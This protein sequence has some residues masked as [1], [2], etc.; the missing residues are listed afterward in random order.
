M[1]I[2]YFHQHF[3]TPNG[4]GGT[5]SYEFAKHLVNQGHQVTIITGKFKDGDTGLKNSFIN[6]KREGVVEGINILELNI[7]YSNKNNFINRSLKFLLFS[8]RGIFISLTKEY[9]II[10]S[11]STP[12]TASIPGIFSKIFRNKPFIFEVRDLWPE[13]P[14]EMGVIKNPIILYL[15]NIL[16]KISYSQA[17]T[18][19]GLSPGIV[20]GIKKKLKKSKPVYLVPNGCDEKLFKDKKKYLLEECLDEKDFNVVYSGTHGL[21]N[22]LDVVIDAAEILKDKKI[23]KIKFFLIGEGK[24]KINIIKKSKL[25][26]LENVI[27]LP[28]QKK[29][30][31]IGLL[32]KSDLGLQILRNIP[33]FYYGTSP[34][35]F[36][37][38]LS[39]GLPVLTNY[40]GWIAD[41]IVE[42]EIGFISKPDNS[43]DLALKIFEAYEDK[44]KNKKKIASI[45]LASKFSRKKLSSEFEK[46]L[47]DTLSPKK[48]D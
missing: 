40:P 12:L 36:F 21:A 33:S 18:L 45:K 1:K 27:F 39:A 43:K 13:L 48:H 17:D 25:K 3:T 26:D 47:L 7:E 24:E 23:S 8:L 31:L 11:S 46:I 29:I 5:R 35:K 15:L 41:M 22:G 28:N 42:N 16:E 20:D 19:I 37:D 38:Y 6:G 44:F 2:L 14:K 34:N 9:D 10:F 30:H 4:S 32:K